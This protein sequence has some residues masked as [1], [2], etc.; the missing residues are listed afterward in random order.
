VQP[1][2]QQIMAATKSHDDWSQHMTAAKMVL[3]VRVVQPIIS[4]KHTSRA[5]TLLGPNTFGQI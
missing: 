5:W 2:N 4:Q 1:G 3:L